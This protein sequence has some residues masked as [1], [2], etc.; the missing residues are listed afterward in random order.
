MPLNGSVI[1]DRLSS[2][3]LA[4]LLQMGLL[5][6]LIFSFEV[7]PHL[8]PEPET[9]LTLP[10]MVKPKPQALPQIIDAR[11]KLPNPTRP[12]QTG[13]PPTLSPP[14]GTSSAIAPAVVAPPTPGA[15]QALG[16]ALFDCAPEKL[17]SMSAEDRAHCPPLTGGTAHKNDTGP[18]TSPYQAK[19]K[20]LWDEEMA[21]KNSVP[22]PGTNRAVILSDPICHLALTL[23][24]ASGYSC[25]PPPPA[26]VS[27]TDAQFQA[28]LDAYH[29]RR[30][31]GPIAT[32]ASPQQLGGIQTKSANPEAGSD[33]N[34]QNH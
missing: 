34:A 29:K 1:K 19:D 13:A 33:P 16:H 12:A 11:G 8:A 6:L 22:G 10:P 7:I 26:S 18:P 31:G 25:G 23:L 28:A 17:A 15:L 9:I 24:F 27:V 3:A 30:G 5:A 32:V 2:L 21:R 14:Q 20:A 4:L